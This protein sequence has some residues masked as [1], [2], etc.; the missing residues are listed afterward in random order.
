MVVHIQKHLITKKKKIHIIINYSRKHTHTHKKNCITF[1]VLLLLLL[2]FLNW[3]II[4][5]QFHEMK[6]L[7]NSWNDMH[8]LA[9]ASDFREALFLICN[10]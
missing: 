2:L 5:I 8:V 1:F 10:I 7:R 9:A 6:S 4:S 3:C